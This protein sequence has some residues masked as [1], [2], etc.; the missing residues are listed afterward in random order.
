MGSDAGDRGADSASASCGDGLWETRG[1][2]GGGV[3]EPGMAAGGGGRRGAQRGA[4][5]ANGRRPEDAGADGRA[6]CLAGEGGKRWEDAQIAADGD[7]CGAAAGD[8]SFSGC[9]WAH[10]PVADDAAAVA[11]WV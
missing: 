3:Q 9:E 11:V 6:D 8:S 4:D 7:F 5:A 2:R 10:E 1:E